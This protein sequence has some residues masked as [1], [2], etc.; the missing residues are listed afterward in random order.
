MGGGGSDI[1]LYQRVGVVVGVGGRGGGGGVGAGQW[2]GGL[3]TGNWL[4]CVYG[5]PQ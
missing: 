2:R 4:Y 5:T 3:Q 1:A